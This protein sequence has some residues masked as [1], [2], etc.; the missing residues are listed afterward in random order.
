MIVR[1]APLLTVIFVLIVHNNLYS[2][3]AVSVTGGDVTNDG[4]SVSYSVGQ[5][6]YHTNE[7]SAVSMLEGVQQPYEI[8]IVTSIPEYTDL[9]LKLS[10]Y[11]NPVNNYLILEADSLSFKDLTYHLCTINGE[12]LIN[13]Q[14]V[15]WRT[16]I[17]LTDKRPGIYIL[18]VFDNR[19]KIKTFKIVKN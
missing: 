19:K 9:K 5:I 6:V 17:F 8:F 16:K 13:N 7:S 18:N 2:Q 12:V 11:P 1:Y 3:S 15:C 14:D 10:A 4:G